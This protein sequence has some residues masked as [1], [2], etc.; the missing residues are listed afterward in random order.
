MARESCLFGQQMAWLDAK[1]LR[2][3]ASEA[4]KRRFGLMIMALRM[5]GELRVSAPEASK[6]GGRT[7]W[8]LGAARGKSARKS[9]PRPAEITWDSLWS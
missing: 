1:D 4:G 3:S 6:K 8:V 2:K 5:R 7:N 9:G